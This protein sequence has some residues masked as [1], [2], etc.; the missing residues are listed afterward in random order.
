MKHRQKKK[1]LFTVDTVGAQN[2]SDN[3]FED[4]EILY[5]VDGTENTGDSEN[6]DDE[7][8]EEEEEEEGTEEKETENDEP[9]DDD[10][11]EDEIDYGGKKE[12]IKFPNNKQLDTLHFLIFNL[13]AGLPPPSVD[14]ISILKNPVLARRPLYGND[15]EPPKPAVESDLDAFCKAMGYTEENGYLPRK[16][17]DKLEKKRWKNREIDLTDV[18]K[19][20]TKTNVEKEMKKCILNGIETKKDVKI[21]SEREAHRQRKVKF[22]S[23]ALVYTVLSQTSFSMINRKERKTMM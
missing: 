14:I 1:D 18:H 12:T 22:Q 19:D 23:K 8:E 15:E 2:D 7:V 13:N 16:P 4:T 11:E 21:P 6:S 3:E 10:A 9:M 20:F 5:P 17:A